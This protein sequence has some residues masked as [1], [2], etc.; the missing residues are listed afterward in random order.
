[1]KR[2][3]VSLIIG[4]MQIKTTTTYPLTPVR[5]AI[6]NKSINNKCWRGCGKGEPFALLV[7]TQ[8]GAATMESSMEIT[9]K[10]KSGSAF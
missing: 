6:V 10:I 5:M 8:T 7:G 1:M 3:A 9:Q 2:R 4:E